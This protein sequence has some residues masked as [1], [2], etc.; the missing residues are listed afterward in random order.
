MT[1]ARFIR[2][3]AEVENNVAF[4]FA[5]NQIEFIH[6]RNATYQCFIAEVRRHQGT[7]S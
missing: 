3:N 5:D 7:G 6:I 2:E 1:L 4:L